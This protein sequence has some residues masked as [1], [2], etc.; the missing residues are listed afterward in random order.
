[1]SI[2]NKYKAKSVINYKQMTTPLMQKFKLFWQYPVITEKTFAI[3]NINNP[4][5]VAFPWATVLDKRYDLNVIFKILSSHVAS[6]QIYYTCCQHISFRRLIPL[7]KALNIRLVY[8]PHKIKG[9]NMIDTITLKGCPLYAVNI[10]DPTRN[11]TFEG[12]DFTTCQRPFLFSFVGGYQPGYLTQIRKN[13]FKMKDNTT[14]KVI[15]NTGDW[16]FNELVY[17]SMQNSGL[18]ENITERHQKNT[19][20]YNNTLIS[21]EFSLCPS[22]SGPNSIRFWESLGTGSIPVLLAD[23]LDLPYHELWSN[24]IVQI[25]ECDVHKTEQILSAYTNEQ[26][27]SMRKNALEVYKF[28]SKTYNN[29]TRHT[30]PPKVLFTSYMCDKS[31]PII[32]KIMNDWKVKNPNFEI[33]YFS[34]DDIDDFFKTK[35]KYY[36][37]FKQMKNGVAK[38]DFFRAAYILT[39]GGYWFDLDMEPTQISPPSFGNIHLFDC[40]FQNISYMLIGA[41]PNTCLFEHITENVSQNV[42]R[43]IPTKYQHVMEIT[44]PRVIQNIICEKL[45]IQNRDGCLIANKVPQIYLPNTEYEFILIKQNFE[46]H[47]TSLYAELQQKYKKLSY[48]AYNFI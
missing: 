41:V 29:G 27:E 15:E 22:G 47:K 11:K 4:S 43:N 21:S 19:D 7:W 24:A 39:F 35:T 17:N 33:K 28:F 20:Y 48:Q 46:T 25:K 14:N 45:N 40:G 10:E 36:D 44:G 42:A 31:E 3:Q 26:K 38:A 13:I 37:I 6:D 1:M 34:D 5:F 12:T 8:T 30:S 9:E 18:Q 16:H 23:T 2:S 32:V